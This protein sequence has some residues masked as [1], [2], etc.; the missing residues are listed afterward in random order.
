MKSIF[1]IIIYL[2]F[3][4]LMACSGDSQ[5]SKILASN[6]D[7]QTTGSGFFDFT[8]YQPFHNKPIKVYFYIPKNSNSNSSIVFIFHGTDR[9]AKYYRDA[10]ISK[11]NQYNFIV[12]A[13]ELL[14]IDFPGGDGYNLGNVFIDGDNPTTSTLN[15]EDQW[16][17]SLIE[18]LF[19]FIKGGLNNV[20]TKYHIIGHSAGGQFANRF[21]M[22]K[23]N[24]KFDKVVSSGSGWYTIPDISIQ[25]PYGFK[26]SPLETLSLTSLFNKNLIIQ[27][28]AL[29]NDPNSPGLR[30]NELADA[31][32]LNRLDRANYFFQKSENLSLLNNLEFNWQFYINEN[33]GHNFQSAIENAADI[34][35]N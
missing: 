16:T 21:I 11:A 13:P 35:F 32:G 27:I 3:F 15:P 4:M 5:S 9:N 33:V 18:P 23:P 22:F 7:Y 28:G 19:D 8:D 10:A 17:F 24:A 2:V 12:M 6:L 31:Q 1:I 26:N 20:S 25:F 14:N 29:D 34:I 30:H